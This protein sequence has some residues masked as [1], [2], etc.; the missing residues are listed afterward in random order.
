VVPSP[1]SSQGTQPTSHGFDVVP[2]FGQP[3]GPRPAL[4]PRPYVGYAP[5]GPAQGTDSAL[6]LLTP[7]SLDPPDMHFRSTPILNPTSP[8]APG[9]VATPAAP[10]SSGIPG[11]APCTSVVGGACPI[12]GSGT[13]GTYTK[14]GSGIVPVTNIVLP[15]GPPQ[16]AVGTIPVAFVP[17]SAN[18]NP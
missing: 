8:R 13:S 10:P 9:P 16:P 7:G 17:T 3:S 5:G 12:V 15:A 14:T 11:G 2:G 4:L 18:P 1:S 6:R